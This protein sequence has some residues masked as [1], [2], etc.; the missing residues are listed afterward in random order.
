MIPVPVIHFS[1]GNPY[2]SGLWI[3]NLFALSRYA[4][5][6]HDIAECAKII[7]GS[8]ANLALSQ[9]AILCKKHFFAIEQHT[10]KP[11]FDV[12][13]NHQ[14]VPTLRL[15]RE[16]FNSRFGDWLA[17]RVVH[18]MDVQVDS[19]CGLSEMRVVEPG[20]GGLPESDAEVI[21]AAIEEVEPYL[22][23]E[24]ERLKSCTLKPSDIAWPTDLGFEIRLFCETQ[25]RLTIGLF[26]CPSL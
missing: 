8:E 2:G 23:R 25:H 19:V 26:P 17:V 1:I 5:Y 15:P 3:C 4:F 18:E 20:F 7:E 22:G 21:V 13:L 14:L 10:D 11:G 9:G 24:G 6:D 12:A 16:F